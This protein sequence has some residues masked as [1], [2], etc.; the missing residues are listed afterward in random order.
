MDSSSK[1]RKRAG[2]NTE[3]ILE[4][5]VRYMKS[6][7]EKLDGEKTAETFFH[8]IKDFN[9]YRI[10]IYKLITKV[11]ELL[12]A[13]PDL[14]EGFYA[15]LPEDVDPL[16]ILRKKTQ[17]DAVSL[18]LKVKW[19]FRH[20]VRLYNRFLTI[21]NQY[22][23]MQKPAAVICQDMRT[24]FQGNEDLFEAFKKYLPAGTPGVEDN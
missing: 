7:A 21:V 4:H 13:H 8:L 1:Q 23:S 19:R 2:M 12:K 14:L 18:V 5:A 20:N 3:L 17:E 16:S 22:G 6:V 24:L 10:D 11:Y 9:E 15:F